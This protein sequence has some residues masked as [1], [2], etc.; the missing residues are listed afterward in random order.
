MLKP[1]EYFHRTDD[2]VRRQMGDVRQM[3]TVFVGGE[4][5]WSEGEKF[6]I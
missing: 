4:K 6:H 2:D 5:D 3:L 1:S